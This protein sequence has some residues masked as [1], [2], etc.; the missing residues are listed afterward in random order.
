MNYDELKTA[1]LA[2]EPE[3]KKRL[4]LETFP[5]LSKDAIKDPTF[6]MQLFPVFLGV[7]RDS[8]ME[9]QQLVQLAS[10]L[11]NQNSETNKE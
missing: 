8:G 1:V 3:D 4:I 6:I 2:L 11:G 10:M 9:L 5:E 7:L